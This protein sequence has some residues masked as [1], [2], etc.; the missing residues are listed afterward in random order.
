[1]VS[2]LTTRVQANS[3]TDPSGDRKQH[4]LTNKR[5]LVCRCRLMFA[6]RS[7]IRLEYHRISTFQSIATVTAAATANSMDAS[8]RDSS[9]ML[10]ILKRPYQDQILSAF[11]YLKCIPVNLIEDKWQACKVRAQSD[12]SHGWI[13]RKEHSKSQMRIVHCRRW[14]KPN[15]PKANG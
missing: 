7:Q 11:I 6:L 8:R 15:S 5:T 12:A 4:V 1:M 9:Y 10:L 13:A 14:A 2:N 3:P